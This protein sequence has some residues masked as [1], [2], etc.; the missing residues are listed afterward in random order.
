M[1]S[2]TKKS[3]V[4]MKSG[5]ARIVPFVVEAQIKLNLNQTEVEDWT[6]LSTRTIDQWRH[7]LEDDWGV[8]HPR[9]G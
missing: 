4:L 1:N 8:I 9:H 7:M 5:I 2:T 3:N 6:L